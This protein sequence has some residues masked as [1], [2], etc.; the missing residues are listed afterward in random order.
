MWEILIGGNNLPS[1]NTPTHSMPCTSKYNPTALHHHNKKDNGL[2]TM[3]IIVS[4]L[5]AGT[6]GQIEYSSTV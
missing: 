3:I 1:T 2:T 6:N 4:L 5:Q